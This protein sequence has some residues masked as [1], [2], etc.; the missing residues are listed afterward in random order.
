MKITLETDYGS[1]MIEE[2]SDEQTVDDMC[3]IF[4]R[5]LSGTGYSFKLDDEIVLIKEGEDYGDKV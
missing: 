5:L 4:K 3:E 2:D 1:V